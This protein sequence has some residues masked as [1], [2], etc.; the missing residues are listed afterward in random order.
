MMGLAREEREHTLKDLQ[1]LAS[2]YW[3]ELGG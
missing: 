3:Q 1:T 2:M